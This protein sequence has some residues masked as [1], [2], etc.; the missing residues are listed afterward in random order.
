MCR[1]CYANEFAKQRY[2]VKN[3]HKRPPF[4]TNIYLRKYIT[5]GKGVYVTTNLKIF[6]YRFVDVLF[7]R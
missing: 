3:S 4:Q 6:I 7:N 2:T 5:V 1:F